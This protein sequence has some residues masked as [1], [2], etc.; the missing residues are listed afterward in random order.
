MSSRRTQETTS[1]RPRHLHVI[2]PRDRHEALC[3]QWEHPQVELIGPKVEFPGLVSS[4]NKHKFDAAL[5]IIQYIDLIASDDER[6]KPQFHN[7]NEFKEKMEKVYQWLQ[8]PKNRKIK[9]RM[10]IKNK[11]N[12]KFG[13]GGTLTGTAFDVFLHNWWYCRIWL[14]IVSDKAPL[15]QA[16][17]WRF[18]PLGVPLYSS[19]VR[20]PINEVWVNSV[21]SRVLGNTPQNGT[22]NAFPRPHAFW[23]KT[24]QTAEAANFTDDEL[25]VV[26][27]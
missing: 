14:E 20:F 7:Y 22:W 16:A 21:I 9:Q 13:K 27:I 12:R 19:A 11:G 10:A 4:G 25:E 1:P 8:R 3:P 18:G 2:P 5:D 15:K 23:L 6:G 24:D 26:N 17:T